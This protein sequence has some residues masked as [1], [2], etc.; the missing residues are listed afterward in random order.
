MMTPGS[1]LWSLKS[2]PDAYWHKPLTA[3]LI[4]MFDELS[5]CLCQGRLDFFWDPKLNMLDIYTTEQ[6]L[7]M[8]RCV[9]GMPGKLRSAAR[10]PTYR[11]LL[12]VLQAFSHKDESIAIPRC[13]PG[14]LYPK[15]LSNGSYTSPLEIKFH[16]MDQTIEIFQQGTTRDT[17]CRCLLPV[18]LRALNHKVC[19]ASA[20]SYPPKRNCVKR[21]TKSRPLMS[22]GLIIYKNENCELGVAGSLVNKNHLQY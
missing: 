3:I 6:K 19:I 21:L 22:S 12:T 1:V 10:D 2:E 18:V 8:Y 5:E 14:K 7:E 13:Y 20:S 4:D 9:E 16:T 11:R 17:S 15:R